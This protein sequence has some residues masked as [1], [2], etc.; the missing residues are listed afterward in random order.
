VVLVGRYSNPDEWGHLTDITQALVE[1][2]ADVE[3][4]NELLARPS[5]GARRPWP[6]VER[7]GHE[8]VRQLLLDRRS[9]VMQ[10]ALAERYDISVSSVKR[11]LR[12]HRKA[13]ANTTDERHG[14]S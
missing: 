10:H 6:V 3:V 5:S 2:A 13:T 14:A 8:A 12:S 9:G 7:I 11:I 4:G 1:P